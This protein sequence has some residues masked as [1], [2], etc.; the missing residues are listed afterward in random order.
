[1]PTAAERKHAAENPANNAPSRAGNA[2]ACT[3]VQS[4]TLDAP[5]LRT[6]SKPRSGGNSPAWMS[7]PPT[8]QPNNSPASLENRSRSLTSPAPNS[9]R[10]PIHGPEPTPSPEPRRFAPP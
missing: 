8:T 3:A 2:A 9:P 5:P 7:P 6:S 1:M 4:L 10:S